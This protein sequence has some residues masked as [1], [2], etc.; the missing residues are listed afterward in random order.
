MISQT[1]SGFGRFEKIR[2]R[3]RNIGAS[4][5]FIKY[6]ETECQTFFQR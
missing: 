3:T 5:F 2:E 1:V 4:P 6:N